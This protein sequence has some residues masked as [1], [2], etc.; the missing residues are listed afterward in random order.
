MTAFVVP[1]ARSSR[2]TGA[3]ACSFDTRMPVE[4]RKAII[5]DYLKRT[6]ETADRKVEISKL[7][8]RFEPRYTH[9]NAAFALLPPTA[10]PQFR[11]G[12]RARVRVNPQPMSSSDSRRFRQNS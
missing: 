4:E 1:T 8:S 7:P 2:L 3:T 10:D 9:G 6:R 12:L 5:Y 11:A